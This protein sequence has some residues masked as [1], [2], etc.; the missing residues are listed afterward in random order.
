MLLEGCEGSAF[1]VLGFVFP[2]TF[3]FLLHLGLLF[4]QA[5]FFFSWRSSSHLLSLYK[6]NTIYIPV[7]STRVNPRLWITHF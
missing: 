6:R 5:H 2:L 1:S 4:A 7:C 3:K